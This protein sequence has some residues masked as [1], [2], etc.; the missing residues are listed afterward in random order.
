VE[1][2]ARAAEA[3]TGEV[4]PSSQPASRFRMRLLAAC[5]LLV[6]L[7]LAQSPG[8]L[9]AD[10]KLD[11]ALAPGDFL[12]RAVHLWDAEGAFGQLQNQAYGYLWPMGPFFL[13]GSL[14]EIP[15]WAVQRLWVALVMCVAMLGAAKLSRALGVR[16]DLAAIAAGFAYALSPRMLTTLGPISIEAW[17][18]ALAPWVLLPLVIGARTGSPRRAAAL[19]ALAVA[20]VGGVNAAAAFAVIP[21]GALWLLTRTRGPRRRMLMTWWPLF[22][23][24]GTFWWLVPL[25]LMGV[26]SPP[27]LDYIES[28]DNTTFPTTLFDAL[29]GTSNWV[30]YVD[31]SWRAGNDLIRDFYLPVNSGV[32]LFVGLWGIA[33]RTNPHRLF[34]SLAVLLGLFAVTMGHL[35]SVEG[36]AAPGLNALLDGPLAPLR[37]VHKFDPLVRLPLVL[38]LAWLLDDALSRMHAA[39]TPEGLA[40]F[41]LAVLVGTAL[42]AV[43]GA[44]LPAVAG[45]LAPSG[46]FEEVPGYWDEAADFLAEQEDAGTALL[47]P[48]T[49][50][51]RYIWGFPRDEPMQVLASSP[52]AVRNAVPL[53]PAGN[54]RMLDA[55]ERRLVQGIP[56][57]GL[58]SY[59]RRAGV[60]H[61]LVRND[62]TTGPD[63]PVPV[64]VHQALD[65]SPGLERVATFGPDVGGEAHLEGEVGRILV[66]GGW[67]DT[68]PALE[69]YAVED[70]EVDFAV[71]SDVLPVVVGGPEDLLD[72]ADLG[73]LKDEPTVLAA[74]VEDAPAADQ[75]VMLTDGLR[76][77]ERHF[78]RAHD[79]TSAT[80]TEDD[81][82]R[83]GNPAPDYLPPGSEPWTTAAAYEGIRG[84]SASS[85]MADANAFGMLEAGQ[86]PY[87]ALDG[88]TSTAWV[89]NRRP[90]AAWWQVDFDGP[91]ILGE[92][93]IRAGADEREIIRVRTAGT[94]TEEVALP[95]GGARTVALPGGPTT[96]L[97]IEDASGRDGHR[98]SLA[99]VEVDDLDVRRSLD[100]PTLPEAWGNPD[101]IVLRRLLDARNGCVEVDD[102]VRCVQGRD[103][104]AEEPVHLRRTVTLAG[105]ET[106]TADLRVQPRPGAALKVLLQRG[107]LASV[108]A[109]STGNRDPRASAFAAVD[110]DPGTTWTAQR[111]D[112]R[113]S[114]TLTWIGERRVKGLRLGVQIDTAARLPRELTLLW[115]GG[116][117]VVDVRRDGSVRLD[118][119]IVTERLTLQVREA[120]PATD[121]GLDFAVTQVPVGIGELRVQG[122]P[123]FPLTLPQD[124]VRLPCGSG[125]K[126]QVGGRTFRTSV[127]ASLADLYTNRTVPADVCGEGAVLLEAG[128]NTVDLKASPLFTA[129]ALVLSNGELPSSE[130][131][132]VGREDAGPVGRTL[133]VAGGAVVAERMNTN[134]GWEAVQEGEALDEVV[135]DG[136]QQGWVLDD[137]TVPIEVRYAPDSSYRAALVA[138]LIG[139]VALAFLA[140][141]LTRRRS[142]RDA[143]HPALDAARLPAP[144]VAAVALGAGGL[145]A[146]GWGLG[147]AL[148]G[149]VLGYVSGRSLD[150]NQGWAAALP[151]LPA[152][153]AYALR[154]W[155]G[156]DPW[157]GTLDWPHYLVVVS[158]AAVLGSLVVAAGP[159]RMLRSR[160][161][162]ISTT[163]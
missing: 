109:S 161:A 75:P 99:E 101:A 128:V 67:Q 96:W 103:V 145:L 127:T 138:G 65:G 126:L 114:F 147:A 18:S 12:L 157:A 111:T 88:I 42:I 115:P 151:V 108:T 158:C 80:L 55:V 137:A 34:L 1:P 133:S 24:L 16:S 47:L 162:G 124:D 92:V 52:W 25:F 4:P 91:R 117:Q 134:P 49:S 50:F 60:S 144:L 140:L 163:R 122:V 142:A 30:P 20:M 121:L 70:G 2:R 148:I 119:P 94:T 17:P 3:V 41:N 61:L 31:T 74:D 54:I 37:N 149:L 107:Q 116:D 123:F 143:D 7:A 85:S 155:G 77:T 59:L 45:R 97:R 156:G 46:G 19:S 104:A 21:L 71:S 39:R 95:P 132:P 82:L 79:G 131:L 44:A 118:E 83:M 69:I 56:S 112:V 33:R 11:L 72:L 139:L 13:L 63:V 35:G 14:L 9:V 62:L 136:W 160:I 38:G 78:G 141:F 43:A 100:L 105:S 90:E 106:Y 159:R 73:L 146:G 23:L 64:L 153:L 58:A 26:Y 81:P 66:N 110:G 68:Y 28:A 40:R 10:T 15:D 48:G 113:P 152:A 102:A 27:F 36:W 6:G 53:T 86:L 51:G 29:R 87:A 76:K 129:N 57:A 98:L 32:L 120:E 154:P 89:A 125:P 150:D 135:V 8:V 5:V 93:T 22:T 84:V 130:V